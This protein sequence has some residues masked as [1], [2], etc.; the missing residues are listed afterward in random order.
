M[1]GEPSNKITHI[2][3]SPTIGGIGIYLEY[4]PGPLNTLVFQT[5]GIAGKR[6]YPNMA[7]LVGK[8]KTV[9]WN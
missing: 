8:L 9:I 3:V 4:V 7:I 6:V 5:W 2:G 1:G